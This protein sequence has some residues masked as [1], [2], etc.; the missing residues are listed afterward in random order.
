M[1]K[2]KKLQQTKTWLIEIDANSIEMSL[3]VGQLVELTD[4]KVKGRVAHLG[5]TQFAAGDWVGIVL[6]EARGRN[7]GT[8]NGVTYFNCDTNHGVF[9]KVDSP[10]IRILSDNESSIDR[11]S[12]KYG[13]NSSLASSTT[14]TTSSKLKRPAVYGSKSSLSKVT[15]NKPKTSVIKSSIISASK[16]E[17][18]L[19]RRVSTASNQSRDDDQQQILDQL[20]YQTI[21]TTNIKPISRPTSIDV[22]TMVSN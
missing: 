4:K 5:P 7:N 10:T 1:K 18:S 9:V 11:T 19:V 17:S 20:T 6:D 12:D 22:K 3:S 8:V 2:A 21:S 15:T 14:S 16:G 13:S